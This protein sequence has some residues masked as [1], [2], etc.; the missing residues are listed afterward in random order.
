MSERPVLGLVPL[1]PVDQG[2]LRHLSTAIADWLSLPVL[3]LPTRPLPLNTLHL[4]RNQHH[5][6][7]LLE[8]LL[9]GDQAGTFRLLGITA[10]DLYIPIFTFVFGEAQLEGKAAI[11]SI[12]RPRGDDRGVLAPREVLLRRLLLLSLH[13]L[14]HTFGL[15]HCRQPGCLMGFSANLQKLDEKNLEF[16]DYCRILLADYFRHNGL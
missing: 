11:V 2:I 9:N 14:G 6:T 3:I 15:A 16:C 4:V 7:Q 5:S 13:E 1:N 8:Y 10:A 12:F